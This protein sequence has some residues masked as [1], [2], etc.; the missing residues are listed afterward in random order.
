[1]L[2]RIFKNQSP[3]TF[4]VIKMSIILNGKSLTCLAL[5]ELGHKGTIAICG[6][7]MAKV[8]SNHF[9]QIMPRQSATP[10]H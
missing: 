5:S 2:L 1:M 4:Q 10:A 9:H 3:K 7:A 8:G 6:D